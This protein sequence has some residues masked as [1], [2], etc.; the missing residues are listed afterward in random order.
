MTTGRTNCGEGRNN[1]K[2]KLAK[3]IQCFKGYDRSCN[4]NLTSCKMLVALIDAK[5]YIG[6][7]ENYGAIQIGMIALEIFMSVHLKYNIQ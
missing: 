1:W 3:K 7:V 2:I 4:L 5:R 6:C